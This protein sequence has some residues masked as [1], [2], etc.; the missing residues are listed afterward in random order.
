MGERATPG[1]PSMC[2]DTPDW[3][4]IK[5]R[6][7][8]FGCPANEIGRLAQLVARF[9]HTEEVVGSSPASPTTKS[10]SACF[11]NQNS[12]DR[13]PAQVYFGPMAMP[14]LATE[15][16]AVVGVTG[17]YHRQVQQCGILGLIGYLMFGFFLILQSDF[18]FAE[19]LV[20]PLFVRDAPP[21][22]RAAL[23]RS[24]I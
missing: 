23:C 17:I 6:K 11:G 14:V 2:G 8:N 20:A 21:I 16:F 12:V 15:L 1:T 13:N 5:S 22:A 24:R 19:A 18:N 10:R 4:S 9:L 7:E 3:A